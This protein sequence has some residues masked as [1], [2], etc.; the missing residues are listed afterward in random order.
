MQNILLTGISGSVG[1]YLFDLLA[2][3]P[4]YHLYLVLRAPAKL[5][6]ALREYKNITVLPLDARALPAQ[7]KLLKTIDYAVFIATS[8]GGY[9]EPWRVNVYPLFRTLR[10]LDPRRIK[11]IIYFSTASILDSGHRPVEAIRKIG[12]NYIRSKFLAH[13]ML[14]YNKL[15]AKIITVFPTWVYGGDSRHPFSHAARGLLAL[16]KWARFLKYFALDFRFHFIHCADIAALVKYLLEHDTDKN[17][18]VLGNEPPLSAGDFVREIA[19]YYGQR[20]PFQIPVPPRLLVWLAKLTG[21]HPWDQ[22]C[23]EYRNFVYTVLN[24][25]KLGL[26]SETDTLAGLLRSLER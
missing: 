20:T 10:A 24:C 6:R 2:G 17:E 8:W 11:K 9:R 22:Y 14:R 25:R 16:K 21:K 19:A 5:K 15:Q 3:D 12:T 13:K 18:Y 1:H 23:L 7:K 4:R 26:P